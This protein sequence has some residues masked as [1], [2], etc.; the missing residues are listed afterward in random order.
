MLTSEYLDLGTPYDY[1]S[2]MHY[3]SDAFA[4]DRSLPSIKA[5]KAPFEIKIKEN[6][7]EIDILKIR[8]LYYCKTG[9]SIYFYYLSFK[10]FK[11]I[12]C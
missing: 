9:I 11:N 10:I 4:I 7:S 12:L 5:I 8:K 1:E 3:E 6:L 2:I